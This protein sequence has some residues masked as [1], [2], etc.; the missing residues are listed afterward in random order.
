LATMCRGGKF[1][2]LAARIEQ[3]GYTRVEGLTA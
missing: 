1:S 2:A 3:G